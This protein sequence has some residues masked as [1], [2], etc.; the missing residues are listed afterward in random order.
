MQS[1]FSAAHDALLVQLDAAA[2][3]LPGFTRDDEQQRFR[4]F[5][6]CYYKTAAPDSPSSLPCH[7]PKPRA[8]RDQPAVIAVIGKSGQF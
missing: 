6:R 5:L 1:K 4:V 2:I 3:E 8:S 7:L